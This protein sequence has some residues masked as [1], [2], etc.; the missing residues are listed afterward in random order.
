MAKFITVKRKYLLY[1]FL[2]LVIIFASFLGVNFFGKAETDPV[3]ENIEPYIKFVSV[4]FDP[5]IAVKN[6]KYG[7]EEYK[8]LKILPSTNF[9]VSALVQ[10]VTEKTMNNIQ[11][12]LTLISLKDRNQQLN[13]QGI[14]PTLEPGATAKISF[15]NINALGD[16]KGESATNGQ[17]EL[18]LAIKANP[19]GGIDQNTEA[20]FTFNVDSSF[21]K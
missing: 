21:N 20:K 8:G 2:G 9:K 3:V 5:Q 17:H 15:E 19:D 7:D 18:V 10:N 4:E 16:A 14:I 11:I 6:V 12:S 1:S 13:K